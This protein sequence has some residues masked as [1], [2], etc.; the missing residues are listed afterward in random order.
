MKSQI[1]ANKATELNTFINCEWSFKLFNIVRPDGGDGINEI[2]DS[3]NFQNY[4]SEQILRLTSGF[5]VS[6][7]DPEFLPYLKT[8]NLVLYF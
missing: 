4:F 7:L 8:Y 2:R 3:A 5:L 1:K 6:S